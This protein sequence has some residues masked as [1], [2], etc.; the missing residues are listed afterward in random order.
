MG[1]KSYL[2]VVGLLGVP[3]YH[4]KSNNP[5]QKPSTAGQFVGKA[6][7]ISGSSVCWSWRNAT[8]KI[9]D[10]T[11]RPCLKM[12]TPKWCW[13]ASPKS[14]RDLK[15]E[16]KFLHFL[17]HQP[18]RITVERMA[19]FMSKWRTWRQPL[20]PPE[21]VAVL[22]RQQTHHH[23]NQHT[24][25]PTLLRPW[26]RH[27]GNT[28]STNVGRHAS[29]QGQREV[30]PPCCCIWKSCIPQKSMASSSCPDCVLSKSK[31]SSTLIYCNL[32]ERVLEICRT[33]VCENQGLW[34]SHGAFPIFPLAL[35]KHVYRLLT[36]ED[37]E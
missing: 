6:A 36:L 34:L 8:P 31:C 5:W 29:T 15:G 17:L 1:G 13:H 7:S 9:V 37:L 30:V 4:I 35:C 21:A 27:Q 26:L 11:P 20:Q 25:R 3:V 28:T 19:V 24:A 18:S 32:S 14:K 33:L 2:P 23:H 22:P 10:I 12:S 16:H